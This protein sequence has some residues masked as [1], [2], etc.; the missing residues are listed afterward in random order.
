MKQTKPSSCRIYKMKR[1][2]IGTLIAVFVFSIIV[3]SVEKHSSAYQI[4]TGFFL[5]IIPAIFISSHRS[6]L[7]SFLLAIL[8]LF[9]AYCVVKYNYYDVI[10]GVLLACITGGSIYFLKIRN[11]TV[12]SPSNLKNA[13]S[14]KG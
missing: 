6:T 5:F 4:L 8:V 3:Y 2:A 14:D 9:T 10:Q 12:F 11:T 1:I 7:L 13:S